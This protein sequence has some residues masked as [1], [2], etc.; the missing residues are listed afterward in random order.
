[1]NHF[2][3]ADPKLCIGCDTCMASCSEEHR[4]YGLQDTPRL[5]VRRD[6]DQSAPVTCHHCEDAPCAE[7][8]PVHAIEH[9]GDSIILN[10][11]LCVSCKLCG[12]ACPFGAID[13]G[14]SH[15]Y[16]VPKHHDT[17]LALPSPEDPDPVAPFLDWNPIVRPVAV[18][19]D[20][21]NFSPRGPACIRHCPTKAIRL[22]DP[23]DLLKITA[24][25]RLSSALE[26][27]TMS[28]F[29]QTAAIKKE[30]VK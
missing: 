17:S 1:M 25:K 7:V 11:S 24:E 20:L 30:A 19:C 3:I 26:F 22:V 4:A 16:H 10:E 27:G 28:P 18:K 13:M 5:K 12:I 23:M 9:T 8:C 15:P 29:E 6:K 21:C 14:G 2:I